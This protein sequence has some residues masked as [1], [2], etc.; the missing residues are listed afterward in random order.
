MGQRLLRRDRRAGHLPEGRNGAAYDHVARQEQT[1]RSRRPR[2]R[3]HTDVQL[4]WIT[5]WYTRLAR[6]VRTGPDD[7]PLYFHLHHRA[8]IRSNENGLPLMKTRHARGFSMI[9]LLVAV[10]VMG[11]G[12]LGITGLQMVSLQNNRGAL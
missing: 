3:R 7:G 6:F 5:R 2:R 8:R 12:V 1:R 11:I 10:L 9:E 4:A